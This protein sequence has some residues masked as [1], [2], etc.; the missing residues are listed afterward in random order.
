[1]VQEMHDLVGLLLLIRI[2]Y[3]HQLIMNKRRVPCLDTY[4]DRVTLLLWPRLKANA[5]PHI[6]PAFC[7]HPSHNL[8]SA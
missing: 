7:L 1:M 6:P 8:R 2:N 3:A 5:W 4:L